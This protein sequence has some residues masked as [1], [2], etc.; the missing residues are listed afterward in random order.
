MDVEQAR[1]A[2][3]EPYEDGVPVL[4]VVDVVG[5]R[6]GEAR[7]VVLNVTRLDGR[8]YVCAPD[9]RG[10]VR[11][12]RSAGYCRVERDGPHG[13]DTVRR[14]HPADGEEAARVLKA[15]RNATNDAPRQLTTVLRLD[16]L[17]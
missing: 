1:A 17:D 3:V 11:N 8:D 12:L 9:G 16:P 2:T 7:P 14:V 10:W 6:S 13:R 5:R 15:Q 4:R